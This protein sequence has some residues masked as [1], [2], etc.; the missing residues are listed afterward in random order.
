ML[1]RRRAVTVME[2]RAPRPHGDTPRR[3]AKRREGRHVFQTSRERKWN[4]PGFDDSNRRQGE[5]EKKS[6]QIKAQ[7]EVLGTK[8]V[9]VTAQ[10]TNTFRSKGVNLT[11]EC[12]LLTA[13]P[14]D[15]DSERVTPRMKT[16]QADIP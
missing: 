2:L 11:V 10:K 7:K 12:V 8:S 15:T 13:D 14:P 1:P 16:H 3:A 6:R 4:L 9:C 5:E